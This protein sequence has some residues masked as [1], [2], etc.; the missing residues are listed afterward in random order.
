MCVYALYSSAPSVLHAQLLVGKHAVELFQLAEEQRYAHEYGDSGVCE[1]AMQEPVASSRLQESSD[2]DLAH[3]RST[4]AQTQHPA[5]YK[6][7]NWQAPHVPNFTHKCQCPSGDH[8][9]G[10]AGSYISPTEKFRDTQPSEDR[11]S[12]YDVQAS[13]M[14]L[15]TY[16]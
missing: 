14:D 13:R 5:E 7:L 8:A 15:K 6:P 4:E 16:E 3:E 1:T 9:A 11:Y 12:R 2:W 10:A